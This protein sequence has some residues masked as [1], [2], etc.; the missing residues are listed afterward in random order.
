MRRKDQIRL[1]SMRKKGKESYN[2]KRQK[3][4]EEEQINIKTSQ[5]IT[6]QTYGLMYIDVQ[7]LQVLVLA[8]VQE[9]VGTQGHRLEVVIILTYL[10]A[11]NYVH[12]FIVNPN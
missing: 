6:H 10:V 1:H 5:N 4:L 3:T 12:V 8:D 11:L 7:V 9:E 2:S